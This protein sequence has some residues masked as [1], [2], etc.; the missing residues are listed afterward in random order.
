MVLNLNKTKISLFIKAQSAESGPPLGTILGNLGVNTVK[1][2]KDFN[3]YTK[4]LPN[5]FK[6]YVNIFINENKS[7]TYNLSLPSVGYLLYLLKKSKDITLNNGTI[8]QNYF[9]TIEDLFKLAKFKHP[10][11]DWHK[12][13]P[14]IMGTLHSANIFVE[15]INI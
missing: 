3:E 8:I 1:F 5:Y 11:L 13:I 2:C 7:F 9:I 6:L 4:E 10:N 12:S 14:I 15:Q